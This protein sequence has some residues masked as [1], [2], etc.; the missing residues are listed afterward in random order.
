MNSY[1]EFSYSIG[2]IILLVLVIELKE[3][4][5]AFYLVRKIILFLVQESQIYFSKS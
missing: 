5:H 2:V 3:L 1:E 4:I